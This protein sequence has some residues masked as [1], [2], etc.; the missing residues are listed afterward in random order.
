MTHS[1]VF[2]WYCDISARIWAR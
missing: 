1:L 2:I